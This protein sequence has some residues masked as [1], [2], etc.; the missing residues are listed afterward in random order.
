M[1]LENFEI[2]KDAIIIDGKKYGACITKIEV[3]GFGINIYIS[4]FNFDEI[5]DMPEFADMNNPLELNKYNNV[6][7]IKDIEVVRKDEIIS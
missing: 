6:R 2:K 1:E 4:R 3:D 5:K 7:I